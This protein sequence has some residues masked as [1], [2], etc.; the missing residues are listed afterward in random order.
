MIRSTL[1]ALFIY[2]F[3]FG[4]CSNKQNLNSGYL[5]SVS[6]A[7]DLWKNYPERIRSLM[8]AID[9]QRSDFT[10]LSE[11]LISGDTV[12]CAEALLDHYQNVD[13]SWVVSTLDPVAENEA[14]KLANALT[15]DTIIRQGIHAKIP[16][17]SGKW[18]WDFT[19]PEKD[20]EFGYSLNGHSYLP[21]LFVASSKNHEASYV[22]TFD[23]ILK[24]WIIQHPLP[25]PDDSI[26]MVL[27]FTK[28]L[29]WRDIGEVEWRTLEAGRRLGA[30]WPQLFYAFIND[31]SFSPATRLLM[32]SSIS[33]QAQYL[34]KYHKKGH[35]WTTMEMNGLALAGLA[36]PEFRNAND[37]SNYAL[38][39]MSNEINRQV[40]LDGI[41]TEISTKTQW[42]ALRRFESVA[43]NFQKANRLVSSEYKQQLEEMYNYLAYSMRP[44]GHQPLNNDSDREDLRERVLKA[45]KKFERPDWEWIATNEQRGSRPERGPTVTFPWGGMHIMRNGWDDQAHWSFFDCGPYGTGHQHRDML[46]IS[47]AAYGEDILVDGGR[48][49]H[50]DY[51]SFDPTI[52]R[53][54]FRSSHSHNVLL[55]N[56]NG[57]KAG[58]IRTYSPLTPNKDYVHHKDYDYATGTFKSGYENVEGKT[59]HTRSVLYLHD[60]FWIVLDQIEI[61]Q[62]QDIQILWHF[63]PNFEIKM[64]GSDALASNNSKINFSISPITKMD[65]KTEIVEGREKPTIQGWYSENY[66]EKVPNSTLIYSTNISR[67]ISFAWLLIAVN[68]EVPNVEVASDEIDRSMTLSVSINDNSPV[69]IYL[70]LDKD[71]NK[72]VVRNH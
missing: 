62:P 49:T 45:A 8:A 31:Y 50:K 28:G 19:G 25:S 56:G 68:D 27:D 6:T 18:Q 44:D 46:H 10:S 69:K 34:R 43:E 24:D 30:S 52:W 63:A 58:P 15:A 51:F 12:G 61:D 22:E 65:W 42:V 3:I 21:S 17:K 16:T 32:L 33:E 5:S 36:F 71:L 39:V 35:N 60:Q 1:L 55:V 37:W 59:D 14:I 72:L 20:D 26:F 29:D 11:M 67:S 9:I 38:E 53:G 7:Q 57:Q 47:I 2:L 54:Y 23:R 13:R 70:P 40:Y 66:G 48:Y 64:T 41:Q 4:G